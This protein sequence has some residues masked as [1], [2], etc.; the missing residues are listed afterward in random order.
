MLM[1]LC[2]LKLSVGKAI[3][4]S[5]AILRHSSEHAGYVLYRALVIHNVIIII[6][7]MLIQYFLNSTGNYQIIGVGVHARLPVLSP[8]D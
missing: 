6:I 8:L 3:P 7:M 1:R 2:M 4:Q 5:V